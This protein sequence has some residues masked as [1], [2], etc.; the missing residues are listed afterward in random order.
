[1]N[2][3]IGRVLILGCIAILLLE[4]PSVIG[5]YQHGDGFRAVAAQQVELERTAQA[6]QAPAPPALHTL[7]HAVARA[8]FEPVELVAIPGL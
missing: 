4:L 6:A 3:A 8:A 7:E 5:D 2:I 1:M